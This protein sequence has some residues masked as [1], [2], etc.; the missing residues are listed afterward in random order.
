MPKLFNIAGPCVPGDHY[1]VPTLARLP[2]LGG[3]IAAKQFFVIHAARQSGKTTLLKALARDLTCKDTHVALYCSLETA[4][5]ITEA[6]RGIPAVMRAI[7]SNCEI[8]PLLRTVPLPA[9]DMTDFT[10]GVKR[11]LFNLA[12]AAG[13]P[14]VVLF[15]EADCHRQTAGC[16]TLTTDD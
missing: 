6:E 12:T 8:H 10:N 1:Q 14:L 15:D 2:Q 4:Q 11:L 5:G 3:L 9:A 7:L 13:K 16:S